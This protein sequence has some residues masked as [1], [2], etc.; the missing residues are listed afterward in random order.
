MINGGGQQQ[1]NGDSEIKLNNS[2]KLFLALW[3]DIGGFLNMMLKY[4]KMTKLRVQ[5]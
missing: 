2:V 5:E 1:L 4:S 3:W